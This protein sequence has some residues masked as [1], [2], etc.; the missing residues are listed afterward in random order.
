M[1]ECAR[2]RRAGLESGKQSSG[3]G[4]AVSHAPVVTSEDLLKGGRELQII[5]QGQVYRLCLTQNN[6][7]ILQK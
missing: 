3:V 2:I 5:H 6:K 7:L 1:D 4:E